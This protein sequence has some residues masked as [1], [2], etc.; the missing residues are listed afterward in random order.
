[1]FESQWFLCDPL[2]PVW[3]PLLLRTPRY[4]FPRE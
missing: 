1:M 3:F 4:T 2:W